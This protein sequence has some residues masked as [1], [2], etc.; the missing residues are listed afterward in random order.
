MVYWPVNCASLVYELYIA[1]QIQEHCF[2]WIVFAS[3]IFKKVNLFILAYQDLCLK[4]FGVVIYESAILTYCYFL[5]VLS[6]L[7]IVQIWSVNYE[8]RI[9]RTVLYRKINFNRCQLFSYFL[10]VNKLNELNV[11]KLQNIF[12]TFPED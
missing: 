12:Q 8:Y 4:A 5:A 7:L 3:G 6:G 2:Y 1:F 11:F 9:F 10:L